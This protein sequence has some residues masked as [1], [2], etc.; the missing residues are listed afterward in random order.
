[1]HMWWWGMR[2][3]RTQL[4]A[5]HTKAVVSHS[6]TRTMPHTHTHGAGSGVYFGQLLG[7]ADALTFPLGLNGYE[8]YKYVRGGHAQRGR[9]GPAACIRTTIARPSHRCAAIAT[10]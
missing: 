4:L 2:V 9:E 8:V 10:G 6:R 7:M 3:P 1:M 5:M